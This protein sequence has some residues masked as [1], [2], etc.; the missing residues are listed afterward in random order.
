MK[1]AA[2][3]NRTP[4]HPVKPLLIVLS[5]PS[6]VGKDAILT[7]MKRSNYPLTYI[8]TATTRP[9]RTTEKDDIDYHFISKEEFK[10]MVSG[11]RLLEWA[12]VYGNYYGVPQEPVKQALDRG[13][14]VIV[15]VDIQGAA[16]IQKALPQAVSIFIMPP[17]REELVQRLQGRASE[18]SFDLSLRL[19][20]ADKE[21]ARL[22]L[23]DYAVVN[24]P[25]EIEQAVA[26]ITAI[27][28][29]EK[30]RV[31]PRETGRD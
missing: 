7:G 30:C 9:K 24:Q 13:E 27:I 19:K 5:G 29:A 25:G 18:T 1:K 8:T 22:P 31:A 21:M 4:S 20:T 15:K 26:K 6:G 3:R 16:N 28:T 17:S 2:D 14:D 23:F 12:N 10:A 11:N